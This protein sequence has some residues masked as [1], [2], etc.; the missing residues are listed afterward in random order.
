[1]YNNR[2]TSK[3]SIFHIA[4]WLFADLLLA[5]AIIF[6]AAAAIGKPTPPVKTDL[7]ITPTPTPTPTPTS[8]PTP[9]PTPTPA[10]QVLDS[11]P[12]TFTINVDPLQLNQPNTIAQVRDQVNQ[13]LNKSNNTS[14]KVG[15]VITLAG[16]ASGDD[17]AQSFNS[18][19]NSMPPFQSAVFKN[20][21][22]LGN[23]DSEFDLEIYFLQ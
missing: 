11:R 6:I 16:G 18:V 20:Y 17:H 21:H 13:Q 5:L 22:N 12:L 9:T 3:R 14:H 10:S 15:F 4:G 1:M 8:T 19:L 7:S 2:R 23:P